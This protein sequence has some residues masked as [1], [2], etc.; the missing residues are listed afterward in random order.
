VRLISGARGGRGYEGGLAF[1]IGK[2]EGRIPSS[3]KE[4]TRAAILFIPVRG[5]R[6]GLANKDKN[7][8]G[9]EKG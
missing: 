3:S 4:K 5:E 2:E 1:Y 6:E 8:R 7:A 9:E